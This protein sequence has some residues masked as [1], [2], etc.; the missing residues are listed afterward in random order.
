MRY[1][2]YLD[3]CLAKLESLQE[4]ESDIWLVHVVRLQHLVD[5]IAQV[6]GRTVQSGDAT[7][8]PTAPSAAYITSFQEKLNQTRDKLPLS[9]RNDSEF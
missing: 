7:I 9:L 4:Y 6:H 8:L 2:D 5:R 1:T 3:E